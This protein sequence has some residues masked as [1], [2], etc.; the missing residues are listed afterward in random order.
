M[1]GGG[2]ILAIVVPKWYSRSIHL[3]SNPSH[4][5]KRSRY[6]QTQNPHRNER[7]PCYR[8]RRCHQAARSRALHCPLRRRRHQFGLTRAGHGEGVTLSG[9]PLAF[10][11]FF[12]DNSR[13]PIKVRAHHRPVDQKVRGVFYF[14]IKHILL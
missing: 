2:A 6:A 5:Q 12:F 11:R 1:L 7:F 4:Q 13:I 14:F 10:F 9:P 8:H 3:G